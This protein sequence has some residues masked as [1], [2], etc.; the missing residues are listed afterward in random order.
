MQK[1][2]DYHLLFVSLKKKKD[3]NILVYLKPIKIKTDTRI[4]NFT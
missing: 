1:E 3:S 4:F 2:L